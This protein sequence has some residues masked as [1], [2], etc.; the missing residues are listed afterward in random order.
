MLSAASV[1]ISSH[2]Y[3]YINLYEKDKWILQ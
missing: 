1:Q 2:L 3:M